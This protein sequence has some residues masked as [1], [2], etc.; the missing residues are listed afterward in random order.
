MA[1]AGWASYVVGTALFERFAPAAWVRAWQRL[2]NPRFAPAAGL[3][4]GWAVIETRGR[5]SG[6][7]RH[8][9]VGGRLSGDTFWLVAAD[10]TRSQ[11]VKNIQASPTVRVRVHGVWRSGTARILVDDSPRRRLWR[12]NPLNSLFIGIAGKQ[13]V[14]V[15]VDL[16]PPPRTEPGPAEWASKLAV[17]L[18]VVQ[19]ADAAGNLVMPRSSYTA[20]LDHLDVPRWLQPVLPIMKVAGS[21][22]LVLGF[23]STRLEALTCAAL[24]GYYGA[25]VGFHLAAG[26]HVVIAAPA[27]ILAAATMVTAVGLYPSTSQ[28][29]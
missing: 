14:T 13:L 9:P 16:H 4:P 1:L 19:V 6:Q 3:V 5:N 7:P 11:Y 29:Q 23:Q 20:H 2:A 24:A 26:D 15:R 27:A 25:A 8:T 17:V 28:R 21:A 18:S 22:G 12:L 10:G